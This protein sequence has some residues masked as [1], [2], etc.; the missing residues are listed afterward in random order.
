MASEGIWLWDV[1]DSSYFLNKT[2]ITMILGDMLGLA[3]LNGM[4]GHSAFL[5]DHFSMVQGAHTS[6]K[7][8][9]KAQYYPLSPSENSKYNP[10]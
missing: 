4:A 7:K 8:G 10:N 9:S 5:G 6:L 2:C 1:L 3:K